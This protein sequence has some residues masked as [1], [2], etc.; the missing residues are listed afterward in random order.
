MSVHIAHK[1]I[2]GWFFATNRVANNRTQ[3]GCYCVLCL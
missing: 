2:Y 3:G 1:L